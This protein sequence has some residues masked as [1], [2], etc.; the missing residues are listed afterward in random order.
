M[1]TIRTPAYLFWRWQFAICTP[2]W[3]IPRALH[4][5][6]H[7]V[8]LKALWP[9]VRQVSCPKL[10]DPGSQAHA[11][12]ACSGGR[13]FPRAMLTLPLTLRAEGDGLAGWTDTET[14]TTTGGRPNLATIQL[15]DL[16]W[17]SSL[18]V[19]RGGLRC[20]PARLQRLPEN[21]R[22]LAQ[23]GYFRDSLPIRTGDEVRMHEPTQTSSEPPTNEP[24][25]TSRMSDIPPAMR[26]RNGARS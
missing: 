9:M 5:H 13:N 14:T 3:S 23:F 6:S 16:D 19:V 8:C 26:Q 21:Y 10:C 17:S 12:E 18:A 20:L 15:T 24:H 25:H 7:F 2:Y 1:H 22:Q 11:T 4:T